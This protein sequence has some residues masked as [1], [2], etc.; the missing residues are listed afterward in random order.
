MRLDQPIGFG[1]RG[2][3]EA[4]VS[5]G[6]AEELRL[7]T[8]ARMPDLQRFHIEVGECLLRISTDRQDGLWLK[9]VEKPH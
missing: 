7:P 4:V 3:L 5:V 9:M 8:I 6:A 2:L 1:L